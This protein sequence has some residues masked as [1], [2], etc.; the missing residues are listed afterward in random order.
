MRSLQELDN[1]ISSLDNIPTKYKIAVGS[2]I[3]TDEDKV[4]LIKRG[5]KARDAKD[6]LEG[7]GGSLDKNDTDL[8]EALL[9]EINEELG[10]IKVQI[11]ELLTVMT[12]PGEKYSFWIIPIYLCRLISGTPKIMEPEKCTAI[13]YLN[14]DEIKIDKLS[15]FQKNTMEAYWKK[16][17]NK[18]FYKV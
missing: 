17:E 10:D 5:N 11:Q 13:L 6:K 1:Y 18:P 8:H 9:R 12:L 7:I 2:L 14:L 3:F 4:I 16:Y 15:I